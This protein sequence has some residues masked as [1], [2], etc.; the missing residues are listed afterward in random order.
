MNNLI[1]FTEVEKE[2]SQAGL[3]SVISPLYMQLD[4][5]RVTSEG[6][7]SN[8]EFTFEIN[9]IPCFPKK[10]VSALTGQAKSGKTVFLTLLIL[11]SILDKASREV[12]GIKRISEDPLKVM[13]IDTEQSPLSTQSIL[14]NRICKMAMSDDKSMDIEEINR[15]LYVFNLRSA[16]IDERFNLIAEGV[17]A[18]HP[19]IVIIDNVRDLMHDI[20]DGE[21]A[22]DLIERLMRMAT[23]Q[24]CNILCVLHQNRSSDNRGLRGWLGTEMMNKV[25]EVFLCQKFRQKDGLKP[26][27]MVEQLMTRKYDM[28]AP[29]CYQLDDDGLPMKAERPDNFQ[30]DEFKD[31]SALDTTKVETFNQEYIIHLPVGSKYPWK[32]DLR[33]L[34]TVV[35][36]SRATLGY[37]DLMDQVMT[38]A[39]IVRKS[40]YEKVFTQAER[41]RVVRKD[42]DS[43]GRVVVILLPL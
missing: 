4:S 9:G 43:C 21:K 41:A 6:N 8:E 26:T 15:L 16:E 27:F 36:G 11:G 23:G 29:L 5:H 30:K 19:D 25:F 17:E 32:W 22:Q 10:D 35:M 1:N 18:Y 40:Y 28:D 13:W 34:F 3:P 12:L 7:L 20:N 39:N 38:E 33:K 2:L 14:K 24:N 42:K 37:Q 31:Y